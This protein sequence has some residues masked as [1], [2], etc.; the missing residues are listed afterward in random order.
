MWRK[1]WSYT[2]PREYGW[3]C[4]SG[5]IPRVSAGK[6]V[7]CPRRSGIREKGDHERYGIFAADPT[8]DQRGPGSGEGS[9][10]RDSCHTRQCLHRRAAGKSGHM[11]MGSVDRLRRPTSGPGNRAGYRRHR[12]PR[13]NGDSRTCRWAHPPGGNVHRRCLPEVRDPRRDDGHRDGNRRAVYGFRLSRRGGFHGILCR[14]ADPYLRHRPAHWLHQRQLSPHRHGRPGSADGPGRYDRTGGILLADGPR[15][16]RADAA[17]S[18]DR[19]VGGKT[20]GR[21]LGRR[22]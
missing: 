6:E 5:F 12:C 9:S 2:R 15:Q 8:P 3:P 18:G 4:I 20:A 1:A 22:Q 19:A 21:A 16:P 11:R 17:H 7:G 13:K 14:S 10:R